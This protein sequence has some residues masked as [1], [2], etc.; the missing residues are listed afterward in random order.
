[1]RR[2][3]FLCLM[4]VLASG[5]IKG[6]QSAQKEK[7]RYFI[8]PPENLLLAIA[9]QPDCP[10]QFE[11]VKPILSADD[12][13]LEVSYQV[14]NRGVKPVRSF[15]AAVWTSLGTGGTLSGSSGK[16]RDELIMPGQTAD[17]NC[18]NEIISVTDELRDKF[19]L[20]GPM[21]AVVVLVVESIKF[22]DGTVYTGEPV[23]R[24]IQSYFDS[25]VDKSERAANAQRRQ[26]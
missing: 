13:A 21:K 1:M 2:V 24:A 26:K 9:S 23:S 25:L 14:R 18:Q 17:A 16:T 20:R 7:R 22:A 12:G 4:L 5:A 6:Q 3:V 19:K 10:L 8:P 15:T 11:N